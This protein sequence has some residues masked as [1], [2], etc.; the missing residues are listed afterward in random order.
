MSIL[1]KVSV[2][3]PRDNV[4]CSFFPM[5]VWVC[6]IAPVSSYHSLVHEHLKKKRNQIF[7][8]MPPIFYT[9]HSF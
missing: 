7:P 3:F 2:Y 9:M 1:K 6:V 5:C 4:T 8:C